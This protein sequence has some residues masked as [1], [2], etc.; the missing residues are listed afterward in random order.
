MKIVEIFTC[1]YLSMNSRAFSDLASLYCS[2]HFRSVYVFVTAAPEGCPSFPA[3][4]FSLYAT[5]EPHVHLLENGGSSL[6]K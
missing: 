1:Q 6:T 4:A 2:F 5:V 3:V